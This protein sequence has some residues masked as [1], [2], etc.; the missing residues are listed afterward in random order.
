M[1]LAWTMRCGT[2]HSRVTLTLNVERGTPKVSLYPGRWGLRALNPNCKALCWLWQ[3][4]ERGAGRAEVAAESIPPARV[5][6]LFSG[7][8]DRYVF[9]CLGLGLGLR[10]RLTLRGVH[11]GLR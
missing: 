1:N 7:G 9:S 5:A 11:K 6:V 4:A 8:V 10:L 3:A 2:D